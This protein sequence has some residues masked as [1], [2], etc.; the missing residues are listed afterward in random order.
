MSG[1]DARLES[2]SSIGV[3]S[4]DDVSVSTSGDMVGY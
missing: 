1:G 3:V 4:G 2:G